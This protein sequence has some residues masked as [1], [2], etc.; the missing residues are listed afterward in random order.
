MGIVFLFVLAV[1]GAIGLV[2]GGVAGLG[3]GFALT[4]TFSLIH[5]FFG[6]VRGGLLGLS[7]GLVIVVRALRDYRKSQGPRGVPGRHD[8]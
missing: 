5:T 7:V 8:E 3:I 2:A 6:V 1:A 4:G